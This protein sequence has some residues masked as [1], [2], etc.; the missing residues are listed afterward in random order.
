MAIA[1]EN[2]SVDCADLLAVPPG[3]SD[4]RSS[5]IKPPIGTKDV[6]RFLTC[7]SVDDGKST[8]IGRLLFDVGHVYTDEVS[9]IHSESIR[10][11]TT[12]KE[13]D[14]ALLL[15]GLQAE[16]EQGITIDVA[17]RFFSTLRRKFIVADAPGHD[18]YTRNMATGASVS[19]LAV[20]L[21]DVRKGVLPQTR[22]HS[23]IVKLLGVR[24][25]V[26]AVNKMDLVHF[27]Q[28]AFNAVRT[29]YEAFA[30]HL[31]MIDV[32]YIPLVAL[33]GD[34]IAALSNRMSWYEGPTLLA[35]LE[36]VEPRSGATWEGMAMPVQWVNRPHHDFRGF[37]G[38]LIS[39]EVTLGDPVVILPTGRTT[40][41]RAI[42][43]SAGDLPKA[44]TGD[45]VTLVLEDEVDVSRGD[46][47]ASL[48]DRPE[49]TD[50]FAAH[51]IWLGH[52]PMLPGRCYWLKCATR[53]VV[54]TVT[55]FR[56]KINVD[57]LEQ[58]PGR[59]LDL[60]EI[61]VCN[62][63]TNQ[64]IVFLPYEHNRVLGAFILIDKLTNETVGA[65]MI[66]FALR[67]AAN[68]HWQAI[69][70]DHKAR[71]IQKRQTPFCLWFTG[72]SGS[73]KSTIAN[74]LDR[75]LYSLG[76]HVFLLDGDNIRHGLNRD[77]GF[78]D[79]DRVENIRRVAE[80]AKLM[81]DAGLIVMVSF[82]SPFRL[83]REM[84]RALLPEG[85]FLEVFVDTPLS[86][87]E[88]RDVKGLYRRARTGEIKN[89]TGIDSS[90]EAPE[91]P[92]LRVDTSQSDVDTIVD[93]IVAELHRREFI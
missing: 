54:A 70:I 8:L 81:V 37:S 87:C 79:A 78:T 58:A 85:Y 48:R 55:S 91:H 20:I 27:D 42:H 68:L 61:A 59:Q 64:P 35:H 89:F 60:N 5:A 43:T 77:L 18:Q 83:E 23:V 51:I 88:S 73:G 26:V 31:G 38:T 32:V 92:D 9:R 22:R 45:A 65:G 72:L 34:N 21:I 10:R 52:E 47:I 69:E 29:E 90:Y 82:I 36:T 53:T 57:T 25:L 44:A 84:A 71:A 12:G 74:A 19:D 4:A 11:G 7:G 41:V 66:R 39:G 40:R 46:V 16:R 15:D 17:Y 49:V 2:A 33:T 3:D 28:T 24:N 76:N 86:V 56:H 80:V 62:L 63:S 67:R 14:Y 50:Q 13:I 6:L 93:E 75:R 30:A 1:D